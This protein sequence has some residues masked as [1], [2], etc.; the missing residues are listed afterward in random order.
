MKSASVDCSWETRVTLNRS[1]RASLSLKIDYGHG[2]RVYFKQHGD[3]IIRLL[4][5]G[6]KASQ[7]RDI[8]EA[9]R[10]AR[11]WKP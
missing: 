5:G 3:R 6:D 7:D 2:Y 4:C 10:L 8:R 11:E 9:K 1:V